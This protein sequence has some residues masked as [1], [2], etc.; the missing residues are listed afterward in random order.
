MDGI[1]EHYAKWHKP[2]SEGQIPYD[3]S[4][5]RNLSNKTNKQGKYNQRHWNWKQAD[6][7]QRVKGRELKGKRVKG[8]QEQL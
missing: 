6:S 8:L 5:N 1:G 7:E 2:G 3:L 4:F